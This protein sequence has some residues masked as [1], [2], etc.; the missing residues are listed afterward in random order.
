MWR[1]AQWSAWARCIRF[2]DASVRRD[3]DSRGGTAELLTP[4][5]AYE[6]EWLASTTV[7]AFQGTPFLAEGVTPN[8]PILVVI[9]W[10][11]SIILRRR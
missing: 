4:E 1:W 5:L 11:E 6:V 7:H 10:H 9:A 2:S 8:L 3:V